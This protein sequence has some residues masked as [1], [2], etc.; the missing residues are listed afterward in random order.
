LEAF[1]LAKTNGAD[2]I[3]F[4]ISQTKDKQNVVA[5]GQFLTETVCGKYDVTKYTLEYLQKNC[6]IK[7]GEP[8]MTLGEM[9]A[10]VKGLFD[11]YFVEIKV[12]NPADA[13]QQT[14]SAIKTV[15][16]LGMSDN[17]IFTSYDK[18]ATYLL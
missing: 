11:Y 9:L 7:N 8:L 6:P 13:E 18:T 15:K 5:H 17:V 1:L 3:E 2:G 16:K 14:L 4:D 10:K 12:Y